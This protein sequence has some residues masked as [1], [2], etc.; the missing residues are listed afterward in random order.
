MLCCLLKY[1]VERIFSHLAKWAKPG[2]WV[3]LKDFWKNKKEAQSNPFC[4]HIK[5]IDSMLPWFYSV[6]DDWR[7]LNV[8]RTSV[9]LSAIPSCATFFLFLPYFD[10]VCG[11]FW[12]RS[13]ATCHLL[14]KCTP[15]LR[16]IIVRYITIS[17]IYLAEWMMWTS[18]LQMWS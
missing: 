14:V 10:V 6:I 7:R 12:N 8:V 17:T 15:S 11:L 9:T 2:F 13:T 18:V 3:M 5:Q 16:R 4:Y 1:C